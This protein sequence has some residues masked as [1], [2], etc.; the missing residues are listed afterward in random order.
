MR[1]LLIFNSNRCIR[2]GLVSAFMLTGGVAFSQKKTAA[3]LPVSFAHGRLSYTPDVRGNRVPDFSFAGYASGSGPIPFVTPRAVVAPVTG[4]ATAAIQAALDYVASLPVDASGF[5]GAVQL[6]RGTYSIAGSLLIRASGVVLRGMGKETVLLAAGLDRR[7]LI[8]VAGVDDRT[9]S[10]FAPVTD[11]YVPVGAMS[12]H[13]G[14]DFVGGD[15]VVISRPS[16]ESWIHQL[17]TDHFGGGITALAWKPGQRDVTWDRT[18]VSFSSGVVTLDA[19]ITTALD[20]TYGGATIARYRWPGRIEHVGVEN[21]RL[22]SAYDVANLK[23]EAHSWTAI[24]LEDVRDAWVR[25]ITF[26]HFTGSAVEVLSTANRVTV[27]DCQSFSPVGEIGGQRRNTFFTEGGQTLFHR[28]YAENGYHDFGTGF[29]APGPI[30]FVDCDDKRPYS[31]SGGL[32]SWASGVLFDVMR[33]D[34]QLLGFFNREQDGQGAGWNAANSLLWNCSASMIDCYAPPGAQNWSFGSWGQFRGDGF[35]SESNSTIPPRSLYYAQL[36]D[37]LGHAVDGGLMPI[38]GDA[39]SSPTPEEAAS[40]IARST[41][42]AV[43]MPQWIDSLSAMHPLSVSSEGVRSVAAPPSRLSP[44]GVAVAGAPLA[45]APAMTVSG[46]WLTRGGAVLVGRRYYEPWWEGSIRPYGVAEAKPAITRFVPGRVG[47]GLTDDLTALTDTMAATHVVALDHNYGLWYDRRRDDHERIRRM[48]GDVWPPFY[49]LPFMR[50]GRDSAW[51]GLSKYDLTKYNPWYW[52][53]LRQF[54]DLADQKGLV[55]IH[56]N[57]FQHNIIEAGAHYADFPWRTANN[58]NHTGFPEP[59]PFAGDKRI[60]MAE[61]FYDTTQPD[62]RA[63]HIAFI[64]QCLENFRHNTGVIQLLAAEYTGPLHFAQFWVGH[65]AQWEAASGVHECIGL[66]TTKDVQDA[67]LADPV[68]SATI[69]VVDIRYWYYEGGGKL[70]APHGGENMAPRQHERVLKPKRPD[71]A[72]VY[73]S[74]R[75]YRDKYPSKA[76]MYSAE[77]CDTFGWAVFMAGGSLANIPLVADPRFLRDAAHM[78]SIASAPYVLGDPAVG[79][80]VYG[81]GPF[82][83]PAGRYRL[84][85][86][87]ARTGAFLGSASRVTGGQSLTLGGSAGAAHGEGS[88]G[89]AHGEGSASPAH[90]E[91]IVYWLEKD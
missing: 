31:F 47:P 6:G 65:I 28:C 79:Y 56:Q 70:Y 24:S 37:R 76:V 87:D 53:R 30:A 9:L 29:C 73:R 1:E 60:F 38:M 64:D 11:A 40:L 90:G 35:W 23:D 51:D 66:S 4:D 68:R 16:V 25:R 39:S 67:I 72:A 43:V 62:R 83:V 84:R 50:S 49:E 17:G 61:Q 52:M 71:F 12:F 34:G 26:E 81:N 36:S 5:R 74:V 2:V 14:S 89:A 63:L 59:P 18:V 82:S 27:E 20:T 86:I 42:P 46:G 15:E 8:R 91:G 3:P 19:P 48:D 69:D 88:A 32:D 33:I 7:T 21:L 54:A 78:R 57:Y 85:R 13:T 44:A 55:L 22:V 80:I 58:I 41:L 75:E 10:D 45:A 77:G